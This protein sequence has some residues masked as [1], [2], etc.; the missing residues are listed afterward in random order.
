MND[1]THNGL[2]P[3]KLSVKLYPEFSDRLKVIMDIRDYTTIQLAQKIFTSPHTITM[4]RCGKRMPGP[5]VL[6]LI[7]K[8]L[9]VTTDFLLGLSDFFFV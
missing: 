2:Y 6:C 4:Y 8:E 7:A 3:K 5:E 1:A 9:N